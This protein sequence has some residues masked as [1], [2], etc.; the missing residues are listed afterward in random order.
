MKKE[1]YIIGEMDNMEF[2]VM[3]VIK[4]DLLLIKVNILVMNFQIIMLKK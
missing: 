2:L 4:V 1:M 3:V